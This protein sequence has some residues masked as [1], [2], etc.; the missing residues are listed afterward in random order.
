MKSQGANLKI[1]ADAGRGVVLILEV[2]GQRSAVGMRAGDGLLTEMIRLLRGTKTHPS[3]VRNIHLD[4]AQASFSFSRAAFA[5]AKTFELVF[6]T[7][8]DHMSPR[9]YGKPNITKHP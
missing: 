5:I 9:Y 6:G 4:V 8:V 1:I 3:D 7:R 2:G